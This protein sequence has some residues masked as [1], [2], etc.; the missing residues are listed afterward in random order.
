M[1]SRWNMETTT[2]VILGYGETIFETNL[3]YEKNDLLGRL[4]FLFEK[5]DRV[6][7]EE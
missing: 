1:L 3:C 2:T 7:N 5:R 6:K 4:E